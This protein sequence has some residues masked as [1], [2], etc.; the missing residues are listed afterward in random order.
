[1]HNEQNIDLRVVLARY[2]E[3]VSWTKDLKYPFVVY[4][5]G[6]TIPGIPSIKICERGREAYSYLQHIVR[7]Y[8][9]LNEFTAFSQ[10]HPFDH[11]AHFVDKINNFKRELGSPWLSDRTLTERVSDDCG[12]QA[13]YQ[14]FFEGK[15]DVTI[16]PAAEIFIVQRDL[17][18]CRTK[19]FYEKLIDLIDNIENY[20]ELDRKYDVKESY[21]GILERL[22]PFIFNKN[23]VA[24]F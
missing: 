9:C 22:W 13:V 3:D 15:L 10:A 16:F 23:S 12:V 24:K 8:Y 14:M 17:I 6:P 4:N 20:G 21:S 5:K 11:C 1:M 19:K 7:E 2:H 18:L